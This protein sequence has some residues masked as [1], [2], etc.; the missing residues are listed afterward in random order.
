MFWSHFVRP[1]FY[2]KKA[3]D[4]L[5]NALSQ[6]EKATQDQRSTLDLFEHVQDNAHKPEAQKQKKN[7]TMSLHVA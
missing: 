6:A 1:S 7:I 3:D 4:A 5:H 2:T